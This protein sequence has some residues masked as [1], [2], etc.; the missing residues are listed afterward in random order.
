M[1]AALADRGQVE[2]TLKQKLIRFTLVGLVGAVCDYSTNFLLVAAG[3]PAWAARGGSYIVGSTVAYFLNSYVTFHG[4]RSAAEKRRAA[5]SYLFCFLAAV[6]VNQLVL[7][8]FSWAQEVGPMERTFA[9][10]ASQGVATVLNFVL[11]NRW[12]FRTR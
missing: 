10:V 9:W 11:Q 8:V 3:L 1:R 7:W 4:E 2:R 12:V 6:V 5:A